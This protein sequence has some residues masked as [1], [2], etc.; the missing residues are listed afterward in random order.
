M[1]KKFSS[2]IAMHSAGPPP[3]QT[4]LSAESARLRAENAALRAMLAA[5]QSQPNKEGLWNEHIP[6]PRP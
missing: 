1:S 5:L 6:G 3:K 4:D 2:Y